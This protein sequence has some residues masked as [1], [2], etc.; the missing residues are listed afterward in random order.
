MARVG[1][2]L[3]KLKILLNTQLLHE[4]TPPHDRRQSA[5]CRPVADGCLLVLAPL[6]VVVV[7][8]VVVVA[9]AAV[10]VVVVV[11]GV[12]VVVGVAAA[13]AAVVVVMVVVVVVVAPWSSASADRT[14]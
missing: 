5:Q 2:I 10:G 11:V 12:G 4:D 1:L 6:V 8:V 3:V 13:A 7:V 14:P 9:A